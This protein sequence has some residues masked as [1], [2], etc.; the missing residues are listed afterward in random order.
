MPSGATLLIIDPPDTPNEGRYKINYNFSILAFSSFTGISASKFTNA[1]PTTATVGG[2]PAGTTFVGDFYLQ[3]MMDL[4]LY[5]A[6]TPNFTSFLITA[7][8]TSL[9]VGDTVAGSKTFTW[10]MANTADLQANSISI[11]DTTNSTILASGLAN[12]GTETIFLSSVTKTTP[13]YNVWTIYGQDTDANVFSRTYTINWKYAVF[14]GIS[15]SLTLNAAAIV[16]LAGTAL[17]S[18]IAGSYSLAGTGYGYLCVPNSFSTPNGFRDSTTNLPIEM[19][20]TSDGYASFDGAFFYS[21]V[22]V[23][24][25]GIPITY[26]VY[27]TKNSITTTTMS[28]GVTGGTVATLQSVINAGNIASGNAAILGEFSATTY[29]SGSTPLNT[30]LSSL[31]GVTPTYVQPGTNITTGGTPSLPIVSVVASPSFTSLSAVTYYSGNTPLNTILGTL[32]SAGASTYVQPGSNITTGGTAQAPIISVS[33]SPTFTAVTAASVFATTLYSGG[34]LLQNV[35]TLETVVNAGNTAIRSITLQG[36]GSG[37]GLSRKVLFHDTDPGSPNASDPSVG[38]D[39]SLIGIAELLLESPN[40]IYAITKASIAPASGYLVSTP[41]FYLGEDTGIAPPIWMGFLSA[42]TGVNRAYNYLRLSEKDLSNGYGGEVLLTAT[43]TSTASYGQYIANFPNKSGTVAML[44]DLASGNTTFVQPGNNITTGGTA[45]LPVVHVVNDPFFSAVTAHS[46]FSTSITGVTYYSGNTPLN[47]ILSGIGTTPSLGQVVAVGNTAE[48]SIVLQGD[49][50]G[51]DLQRKV[52]FKET[53]PSFSGVNDAWIGIDYLL[54]V[55]YLLINSPG[56]IYS[57]T[58]GPVPD[59]AFYPGS[60]SHHFSF[61]QGLGYSPVVNIGYLSAQTASE[62]SWNYITLGEKDITNNY[63]STIFLTATGTTDASN[64]YYTANFQK[65]NGTVAYLDD[66]TGGTS[67]YVQPGTNITTG[68]TQYAPVVN[69]VDSPFFSAVTADSVFA[70]NISGVTFY[71]GSTPFNTILSQ[72]PSPT[73]QVV[74][75]AGNTTSNDIYMTSNGDPFAIRG[76]YFKELNAGLS[77]STDPFIGADYNNTFT[78]NLTFKSA[79]QFF[80]IDQTPLQSLSAGITGG[81]NYYNTNYQGG[82]FFGNATASTELVQYITFRSYDYATTFVDNITIAVTGLTNN[83]GVPQNHILFLP[84]KSGIIATL[85]DVATGGTNTYV[86]PGLNITTGGTAFEPVV[87]LAGT[88]NLTGLTVVAL[89]AT[90]ISGSSLFSGTTPLQSI[91]AVSAHTHVSSAI[92]DASFGLNGSADW[93]KL[94]KYGPD[95]NL[96]ASTLSPG[97]GY[98]AI[99]ALSESSIGGRAIEA[100]SM[101][102]A[103]VA[104]FNAQNGGTGIEVNVDTAQAAFIQND[105]TSQPVL[106]AQNND[107]TKTGNIAWLHNVDDEGVNVLSNGGLVWTSPTGSGT[108]RTNLGLANVFVAP[109]VNTYT[110]STVFN[111]IV[112]VI[113]SPVFTGVTAQFISGTSISADTYYSGSTPLNTILSVFST[114]AATYV[115][116]G[117]NITTGGTSNAPIINLAGSISLT[118]VTAVTMSANSLVLESYSSNTASSTANGVRLYDRSRAG[119]NMLETKDAAGVITNFQPHMGMTNVRFVKALGNGGTTLSSFGL[120]PIIGGTAQPKTYATSSLLASLQ[121]VGM[122]TTATPSTSATMI[123]NNGGTAPFWLGNLTNAGGFHAIFRFGI[124]QAQTNMR[125]FVG[126]YSAVTAISNVEPTSLGTILGFG[127]NSGDT[128]VKF[129][130]NDGSGTASIVDFGAAFPATSANTVYE[131]HLYATPNSSVVNYYLERL[132]ST[133]KIEGS[134]NTNV[135]PS[136]VFLTP[137]LYINNATTSADAIMDFIQM[138]VETKY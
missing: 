85:D 115:Q 88:I 120:S 66:V 13:D 49:G 67:T 134:V 25:N 112:G 37:G 125:W 46:V 89:S 20:G 104:S 41:N 126:M 6:V 16:A 64:T 124:A 92:T 59:I 2:I 47:T 78:P 54:A 12:D 127:I 10:G 105:S 121:R 48:D 62:K 122:R 75:N 71:S 90:S 21:P 38:V 22:S 93:T 19:A 58:Y 79:S 106:H 111:T 83:G 76:I 23:T 31:I 81:F 131:A 103:T 8:S 53:N 5:P 35:L 82:I 118:A 61:A 130:Y 96:Q 3:D 135:P 138:Q 99:Y 40:T 68:G 29:Y 113:G 137:H 129:M 72:L 70:T 51:F 80:F 39:M 11:E 57:F 108:T 133:D 114:A 69:V 65:K 30:I 97:V 102:G 98:A 34:S 36:D 74:T 77:G 119:R 100:V 50:G 60:L 107:V 44:S 15:A 24:R 128:N 101:S 42:S 17:A 91:F 27:R 116:S 94:V 7:Q 18:D 9:E 63:N 4:L 117:L 73:L 84:V 87:S 55:G 123:F 109:G 110:A 95:G 14:Y 86:Q 45:T 43:G 56:P 32:I 136:T 1:N 52:I 132:D 33:G 28:V 26:R